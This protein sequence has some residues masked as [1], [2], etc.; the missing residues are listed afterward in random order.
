MPYGGLDL[1]IGLIVPA[2]TKLSP[3]IQYYI[4]FFNEHNL[5]YKVIVWDKKGGEDASD[6][7]FNYITS[8]GNRVRMLYG[9]V[10][11]ALRCRKI[12]KKEEINHLVI[13]TIAPLFFLGKGYLSRFQ[14][15]F[16]AD[17]R[18][19]SP[20]RRYFSGTL[21]NICNK[22]FAVVVSSPRYARWFSDSQICHNANKSM[23]LDALKY[24]PRF[25]DKNTV[26]IV[27]AG[28][29]IEPDKNIQILEEL[30]N[31]K[32]F[33]FVFIGR[34]NNGKKKVEQYVIDNGIRNVAFQ[35]E[36]KKDDILKIY[37]KE[38][39]LVNI[40]RSKSDIN[41]DALPN[42]LYDAAMSGIPVVVFSHNLA[43][44]DYVN[45]Y[46]LGIVLEDKGH[47][48]QDLIEKYESFDYNK[49]L[50]GR[51]SFLKH[52]LSDIERFETI[53]TDFTK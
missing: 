4:S 39:D 23:L 27:F 16:I 19:D 42:K 18:D 25:T 12:I 7:T 53:L 21:K 9:H 32:E 33:E 26:R 52:I 20:F 17:I 46:Y 24:T 47:I 3:Y 35:G 22:A 36:Y 13:F 48:R 15:K 45:E 40:F 44:S 49:Y 2:N 50:N 6:F 28:T 51:Q 5:N 30:K 11:F 10:A 43:V 38:A 1:K 14:D 37:R 29:L 8:D 31:D 34:D 41:A